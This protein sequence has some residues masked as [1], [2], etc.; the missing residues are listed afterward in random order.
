MIQIGLTK[1]DFG[2]VCQLLVLI[3][4]YLCR[5]DLTVL[6]IVQKKKKKRL[7]CEKLTEHKRWG[8]GESQAHMENSVDVTMLHSIKVVCLDH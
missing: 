7:C 3:Q 4:Y 1:S 5:E 2:T 8:T 6:H